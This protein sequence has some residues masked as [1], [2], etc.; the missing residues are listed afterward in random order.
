MSADRF[1]K[2]AAHQAC[3]LHAKIGERLDTKQ[4]VSHY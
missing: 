1:Q 3:K 4:K 2:N